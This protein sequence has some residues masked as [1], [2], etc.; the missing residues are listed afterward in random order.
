MAASAPEKNHLTAKPYDF[1]SNILLQPDEL[2]SIKLVTEAF[3]EMLS[4]S[5]SSHLTGPFAAKYRETVVNRLG[6]VA[7]QLVS[8]AVMVKLNID[9]LEGDAIFQFER[10]M[11]FMLVDGFLGGDSKPNAKSGSEITEFEVKI[12]KKISERLVRHFEKACQKN[13]KVTAEIREV[14]TKTDNFEIS[15]PEDLMTTIKLDFNYGGTTSVFSMAFPSYIMEPMLKKPP[16]KGG[17]QDKKTTGTAAMQPYKYEKMKD[18]EI[19]C[20][21]VLSGLKIKLRDIIDVQIGDCIKLE[22]DIFKPLEIRFGDNAKF[23]GMPGLR[24]RK[25]AVKVTGIIKGGTNGRD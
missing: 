19:D 3:A 13:A 5:F 22:Q 10:S 24:G 4:L 21:V 25:M 2:K 1:K 18:V 20:S 23:T 11:M 6:Q 16:K 9:G 15:N 14:I 8:P 7:K 17:A 12:I